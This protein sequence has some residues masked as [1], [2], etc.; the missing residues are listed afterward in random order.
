MRGRFWARLATVLTVM[1][2]AACAPRPGPE[3]LRPAPA[4]TGA[5]VVDV[6]VASTRRPFAR[7]EAGFSAIPGPMT[8]RS[9][10]IALA[11][12]AAPVVIAATPLD[13]AAFLRAA[14]SGG[15]QAGVF[16][17]GYNT[18][19]AESLFGLARL[20]ADG[21]AGVT[22]VL[23]AWPSEGQPLEYETDRQGALYS[24]DALAGLMGDLS[25]R[26]QPVLVF[27][28]SMGSWLTVEALRTL[29][30]AGRQPALDRLKVVL[31]APDID[32]YLFGQQMAVI[33]KMRD[34]LVV[35][36]APDD[37]VLGLSSTLGGGRPRLGR[38]SVADPAVAEAAR[39]AGVVVLDIS[40]LPANDPMGHD[41]YRALANYAQA[42]GGGPLDLRAVGAFVLNTVDE[43]LL[44]PVLA[45]R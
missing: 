26:S 17:H 38:L 16:V 22:P 40:A 4:P 1:V 8:Y 14:A 37:R 10:R 24:R 34:P 18:N 43:G 25:R 39:R 33:G 20:S 31:A 42:L 6:L 35:L 44:R 32:V 30:L 28:H 36:V 9:Y 21:P 45:P 2:L 7:P 11:K 13:R 23:F 12:Q 5:Q 27:G 15:R 19:F 29:K 3:D 41:R